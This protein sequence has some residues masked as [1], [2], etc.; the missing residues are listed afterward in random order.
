MHSNG[1]SQ[2][3][4]FKFP[5]VSQECSNTPPPPPLAWMMIKSLLLEEKGGDVEAFKFTVA[6]YKGEDDDDDDGTYKMD[7]I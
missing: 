1:K 3:F 2:H 4:W 5:K 6:L 7:V